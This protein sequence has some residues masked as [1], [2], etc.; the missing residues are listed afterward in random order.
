MALVRGRRGDTAF[1]SIPCD[2]DDD[3]DDADWTS[4]CEQ[5]ARK[6]EHTMPV[7]H[8]IA[9][10]VGVAAA[11]NPP[12]AACAKGGHEPAITSS[13]DSAA[14]IPNIDSETQETAVIYS[15]VSAAAH[16]DG[17]IKLATVTDL[18]EDGAI[19]ESSDRRAASGMS[20]RKKED[21]PLV[22]P[23][24]LGDRVRDTDREPHWI[25]GTFPTIFPGIKQVTLTTFKSRR[26]TSLHG[27]RTS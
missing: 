19:R 10:T 14:T 21:K 20:H 25:P 6:P 12:S 18:P 1:P 26:S 7:T 4:V 17:D 3:D 13:R 15:R 27:G 16:D 23:P 11:F 5:A 8:D 22:E 2:D 9:S 24:I